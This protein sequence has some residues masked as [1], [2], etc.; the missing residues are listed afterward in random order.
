MIGWPSKTPKHGPGDSLQISGNRA[1]ISDAQ[2]SVSTVL[3]LPLLYEIFLNN[4]TELTLNF[5]FVFF[6]PIHI[7]VNEWR[8]MLRLYKLQTYS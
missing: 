2:N 7:S 5:V 1:N 8:F 4:H 6:F 3:E